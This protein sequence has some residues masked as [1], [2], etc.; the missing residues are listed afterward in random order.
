MKCIQCHL[1]FIFLI[2]LTSGMDAQNQFPEQMYLDNIK[3]ELQ[4]E[5]P[6]NR[7]INIV[8]HGHSVPA[9][10]FSTP[11]VNTLESY[12]HLTLRKIKESYPN[13]VVNVILTA[14]GGEHSEQGAARFKADVMNHKPD[15]VVIDYALNDRSIG[16]QKAR[17]SWEIMIKM[18]KSFEVKVIL[19][20]PSPDTSEDILQ[21]NA[22]LAQHSKQIRELALLHEVG[23]VDSYSIFKEIAAEESLEKYMAQSNHINALGH[24]LVSEQLFEWFKPGN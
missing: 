6:E 22:Q 9:G 23:L 20:T 3:T 21:P 24:W 12:P 10:Y 2:L 18:A 1:C 4:L 19:L 16:L 5:W 13:A 8:F 15:L 11:E 14:I 17:L 7:T